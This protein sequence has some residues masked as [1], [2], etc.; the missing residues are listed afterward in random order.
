MKK[1]R[2]VQPSVETLSVK[3]TM[4]MQTVSNPGIGMGTD[5]NDAEGD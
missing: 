1:N 5:I 4:V 3:S 2:Y